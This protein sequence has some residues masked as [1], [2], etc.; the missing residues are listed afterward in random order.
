MLDA[1]YPLS[2]VTAALCARW[3]PGVRLLPMTDDRVARYAVHSRAESS[4]CG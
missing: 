3:N 2:E 1:G 4:T